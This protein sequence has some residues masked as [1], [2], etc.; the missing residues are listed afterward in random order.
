M[1]AAPSASAAQ[2]KQQLPAGKSEMHEGGAPK[3]MPAPG[4]LASRRRQ[5]SEEFAATMMGPNAE[6]TFI[7]VT[8]GKVSDATF[9]VNEEAL[10]PRNRAQDDAGPMAQ[11]LGLMASSPLVRANGAGGGSRGG[12]GTR[13][14]AGAGAPPE[15]GKRMSRAQMALTRHTLDTAPGAQGVV[16]HKEWVTANGGRRGHRNVIE[17]QPERIAGMKKALLPVPEDRRLDKLEAKFLKETLTKHWLFEKFS[18]AQ[19]SVLTKNCEIFDLREGQPL[20]VQGAE[21]D[22]RMYILLRGTLSVH[23]LDAKKKKGENGGGDHLESASQTGPAQ[24]FF[25]R[26][27]HVATVLSGGWVGDMALLYRTTRTATVIAEADCRV[28]TVPR[29]AYETVIAEGYEAELLADASTNEFSAIPV[30]TNVKDSNLLTQ[31]GRAMA[32]AAG[33]VLVESGSGARELLIITAGEVDFT[34]SQPVAPQGGGGEYR[35]SLQGAF[36]AS[37]RLRKGDVLASGRPGD[38]SLLVTLHNAGSRGG[39]SARLKLSG[40]LPKGAA[41]AVAVTAGKGYRFYLPDIVT[42]ASLIEPLA[43]SLEGVRALLQCTPSLA[44]S[45]GTASFDAASFVM[46]R[47]NFPA[48]ASLPVAAAS[49][50]GG[51]PLMVLISGTVSVRREDDV[52]IRGADETPPP[53]A[54][55][56]DPKK[57]A[58]DEGIL[59]RQYEVL[60][61]LIPDEAP[62]VKL[63]AKSA[64]T[65]LTMAR[66]D[67]ADLLAKDGGLGKV[68][69]Y[70]PTRPPSQAALFGGKADKDGNALVLADISFERKI[71]QGA[72][73]AVYLVMHKPTGKTLAAKII[74]LARLRKHQKDD[75]INVERHVMQD[76]DNP[77]IVALYATFRTKTHLLLVMEAGLG[78]ELF[79]FLLRQEHQVLREDSGTRAKARRRG[80]GERGGGAGQA[81]WRVAAGRRCA[82]AQSQR[83]RGEPA[84]RARVRR[85]PVVIGS[86]TLVP[87]FTL[88]AALCACPALCL[89]ASLHPPTCLPRAHARSPL[90]RRVRALGP[91]GD[92]RGRLHVPRP[93]ARERRD[94]RRRLLQD[95]RLWYASDA[96]TRDAARRGATRPAACTRGGDR[97]DKFAVDRRVGLRAGSPG[98]PS[99]E[100][101]SAGWAA[102]PAIA[103]CCRSLGRPA[104]CSARPLTNAHPRCPPAAPP[105]HCPASLARAQASRSARPAARTR[106]AARTPTSRPRCSLCRATTLRWTIG[107]LASSSTRWPSAAPPSTWRRTAR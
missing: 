17:S 80:E 24:A 65:V 54:E 77:F 79:S 31:Q 20:I 91:G 62:G 27:V 43:D 55:P 50:S 14:G 26:G 103:P 53:R 1:S 9:G 48:G 36:V 33:D 59:A 46:K 93:Q 97:R 15:P 94:H 11:Q 102:R 63:V 99:P 72:Y 19:F 101:G 4:T 40:G 3:T 5:S 35:W 18:D 39:L 76:S 95:C 92:A 16:R 82:F 47:V 42:H 7:P 88:R 70:P 105:L 13:G 64:V 106:C 67:H 78:G 104:A 52:S 12:A 38:E 69:S 60:T 85:A 21:D 23:V 107:P 45:L 71:G 87:L 74:K 86:H 44:S 89:P 6:P 61:S 75:A 32:W 30:L 66:A 25:E 100:G 96:S 37:D 83:Q 56:A 34:N 58:S 22:G 84:G 90:L 68:R 8:K 73:G 49:S 28:L 2:A 29:L 81:A 98:E 57:G 10:R 41:R 51:V